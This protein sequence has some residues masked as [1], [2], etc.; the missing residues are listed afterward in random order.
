LQSVNVWAAASF[1]RADTAAALK[2][3]ER[4]MKM[5]ILS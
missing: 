3:N 5:K 1:R 2:M 4:M